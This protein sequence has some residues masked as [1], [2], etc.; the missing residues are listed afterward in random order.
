MGSFPMVPFDSGRPEVRRRAALERH[1]G[2]PLHRPGEMR[3]GGSPNREECWA[4]IGPRT[5]AR[6]AELSG[7]AI[8]WFAHEDASSGDGRPYAVT[9]GESGLSIADPRVD[10]EHRPVYAISSFQLAPGTLRHVQVDHR[11]PPN[12]SR[13]GRP[14]AASTRDTP[15]SGLALDDGALGVLG[16]LPAQAQELLQT[17]FL[18]GQDILRNMWYYEGHDH[19]LTTF[20]FFIAGARDVTVATGSKIVPVGHTDATAHWS[21]TCYRAA[22]ARRIGR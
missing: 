15:P 6:L 11:P 21:L 7:A 5:R 13:P 4:S 20:V 9:F 16:N 8:T 19:H 22:V 14:R 17:P 10:T 1:G 3:L 2:A 18:G 12:A